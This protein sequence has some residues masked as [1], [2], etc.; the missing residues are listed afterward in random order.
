M[1]KLTNAYKILIGEPERKYH[2]NDLAVFKI[3]ILNWVLK[4]V[5]EVMFWI[6]VARGK[7]RWWALLN[8]VINFRFP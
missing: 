2:L 7:D 5:W 6:H 3:I 4:I 8:A 1:W